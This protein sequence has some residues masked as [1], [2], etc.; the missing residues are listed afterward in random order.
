M[1][2]LGCS[3]RTNAWTIFIPYPHAYRITAHCFAGD[4]PAYFAEPK[5]IKRDA[6][7]A[8]Q[9]KTRSGSTRQ[10][11]FIDVREMFPANDRSGYDRLDL[12]RHVQPGR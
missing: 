9:P 5:A 4:M 7:A 11:A 12:R 6:I 10:A 3:K 1:R 8:R 2:Q